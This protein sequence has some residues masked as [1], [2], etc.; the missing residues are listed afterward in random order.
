MGGALTVSTGA[1]LCGTTGVGCLA[2][3]P[4][5]AFGASDATQGATMLMDAYDGV[6]S[7]GLNPLKAGIVGLLPNAGALTYDALSLGFN[8]GSLSAQAPMYIGA[9]DGIART[10][11]L[12][13]VTTSR[14]DAA[15]AFANSVTGQAGQMLNRATLAGSALW[16]AYGLSKD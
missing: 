12:F 9:T 2:G 15:S 5:M 7:Q 11:S 13:G 8:L 1:T 10:S 14:W 16:K 4:M 3:A 6:T